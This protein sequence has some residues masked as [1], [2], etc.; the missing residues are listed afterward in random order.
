VGLP[1]F[2][3]L[4]EGWIHNGLFQYVNTPVNKV[5]KQN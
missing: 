2:M 3:V 1:Y 4:S 5:I